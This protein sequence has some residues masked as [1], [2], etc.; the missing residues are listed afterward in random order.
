[1]LLSPRITMAGM[2]PSRADQPG[3]IGAFR[4]LGG[5]QALSKKKFKAGDIAVIDVPDITRATAQRLI[6]LRPAAVI[7]LAPFSTGKVPNFGPQILLD[8]DIPLYE[9]TGKQLRESLRDGKKGRIDGDAIYQGDRKIG[10]AA[11][12][13]LDAAMVKFNESREALGDSVEALTGNM[14]EFVRSEAPLLVDGLGIPDVGLDFD[15]R[16]ALI[17][18]PNDSLVSKFKEL[19][20]Y[21]AE[22]DPIII[23]VDT[24]ADVVIE[25]GY[26]PQVVVGS[27]ERLSSTA[28]RSGAAVILPAE[29]DGHVDGLERIQD[30]GVG[31]MTFPAATHNAVDLALLFA[32]HHGASVIVYLG[33]PL[34]LDAL[35]AAPADAD[36]P[37]ALLTRLRVGSRL[38][39]ST[40]IAELNRVQ[41]SQG[42]WAWALLGVLL[43]LGAIV[44]IVGFNGD[45]SFLDNII[46]AWNNI[47]L[48]FQD[49]VNDLFQ[50]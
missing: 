1:M 34:D 18:A 23:A 50:R 27:P 6:D 36:M 49:L 28:L 32:E 44:A 9:G 3:I 22:Q 4:N 35:F 43:A 12:L 8:A 29:P 19:R 31:A 13:S 11:A 20:S 14:A 39:D 47:A 37:S 42:G 26:Q 2:K 17:V 33:Q 10:M 41:R 30:L 15:D 5:V 16:Q 21:I 25:A 46:N 48:Q 40:T 38:V 7:N 24:A 45:Q